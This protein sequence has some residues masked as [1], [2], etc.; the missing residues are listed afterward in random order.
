MAWK[1][2]SS[3]GIDEV[4]YKV[5]S[6]THGQPCGQVWLCMRLGKVFLRLCCKL[7]NKAGQ[8]ESRRIENKREES[9]RIEK[10]KEEAKQ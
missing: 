9:R 8:I 7:C 1:G 4:G 3:S 5:A 10:K 2:Q 6:G